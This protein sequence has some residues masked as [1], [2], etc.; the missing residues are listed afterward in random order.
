MENYTQEEFTIDVSK[1]QIGAILY[2]AP[3]LLLFSGFFFLIWKDSYDIIG[4]QMRIA[5]FGVKLHFISLVIIIVGII[6]HELIHG[7]CFAYFAK[8]KFKSIKFGVIW[9]W[10]TPYCHCK[11]PLTIKACIIVA[12]MPGIVL[13]FLPCIFSIFLG[14]LGLLLFGLF[15]TLAA[16]G[17]FMMIFK[18]RKEP[19]DNLYQDHPDK[20]GGIVYRKNN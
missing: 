10:V 13:G 8:N 1:V 9:K 18:L 3:F 4:L 14:N 16:G 17:D 15:F 7:I 5:T 12:A 19:I 6:V 2:T 11:E 20:I